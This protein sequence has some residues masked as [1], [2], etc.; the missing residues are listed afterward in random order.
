VWSAVLIANNQHHDRDARDAFPV[1]V[2]AFDLEV[3]EAQSVK[4][5]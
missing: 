2:F 3:H 4:N 1:D 5:G